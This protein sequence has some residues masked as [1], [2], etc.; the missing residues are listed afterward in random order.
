M[1][2]ANELK[3]LSRMEAARRQARV[4]LDLVERQIEGRAERSTITTRVKGRPFGRDG[5]ARTPGDERLF[6]EHLERL[7][8]ARRRE[9]EALSRKL[10][11]QDRAIAALRGV[12]R[13]ETICA[14]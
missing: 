4:H 3:L 14:A 1:T 11:R 5:P 9:I 6:R 8:F 12:L 7:A 2:T 13:I 10:A